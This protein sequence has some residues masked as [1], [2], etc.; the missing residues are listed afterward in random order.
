MNGLYRLKFNSIAYLR[1]QNG[2]SNQPFSAKKE[3]RSFLNA[4]HFWRVVIFSQQNP[5]LHQIPFMK[6]SLTLFLLLIL[7]MA[8]AQAQPVIYCNQ[9]GFDAAWPKMA[10]I[11]VD[12][13]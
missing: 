6:K 3:V 9:V 7:C 5:K 12:H 8:Y 4:W 11:G 2:R 13:P 1:A 10:V